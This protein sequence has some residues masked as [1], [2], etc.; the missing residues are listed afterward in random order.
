MRH[1]LIRAAFAA[2]TFSAV[3]AQAAAPAMTAETA[4]G[5][6]LVD[7]KSMTLYTFDKD[8]GGKSMCNGPCATNWPA[9]MAASGSAASGDWTMVTRDD[10]TMQWAYKGKPLYTFAKDTKPGDITG[11]G[12]LN[13]AWH[14]AKP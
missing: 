10:G 12:F 7:A 1:L 6:A 3:A 8:M 13:G 4:K 2:I 14:I 9:L 11:D 5:P